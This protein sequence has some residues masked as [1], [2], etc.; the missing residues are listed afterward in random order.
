[1][2]IKAGDEMYLSTWVYI[3]FAQIISWEKVIVTRTTKTLFFVG[4]IKFKKSSDRSRFV[5]INDK[6][7][8][9]V[10]EDNNFLKH[11]KLQSRFSNYKWGNIDLATLIDINEILILA[12]NHNEE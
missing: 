10:I 12:E 2:D 8:H 4:D 5:E 9:R 7:T 3:N 11:K 1:M 6:T